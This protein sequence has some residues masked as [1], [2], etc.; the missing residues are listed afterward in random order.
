MKVEISKA[1]KEVLGEKI[2]LCVEFIKRE[3]QPHL[4]SNDKLVVSMGEELDLHITSK[5]LYVKYTRLLNLGVAIP[6]SKVL[7][8]ERDRKNTKK[9]ICDAE[10]ELAVAF[11]QQWENAKSYLLHEVYDKNQAVDKLNNFIDNFKL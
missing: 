11:L 8:L 2:W 4:I 10:P 7:L 6:I 9:Y 1:Q 5:Q 3:I